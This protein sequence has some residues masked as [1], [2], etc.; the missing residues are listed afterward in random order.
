MTKFWLIRHAL[1]EEN[2]RAMLYGVMDVEL[3][4]HTLEAQAPHYALL[5][6]AL[7]RNATWYVTPL[8]RTRRTAETIM[9]HGYGEVPYGVEPGLI[10][11]N[12]GS[13]Q[14]LP[15]AQLPALLETPAH[16]FWPVSGDE[17]PPGGES[18]AEM[19]DRVG[20]AMEAL[21]AKHPD[22]DVVIVSHGGAIRA[23]ELLPVRLLLAALVMRSQV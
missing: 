15:H 19:I 4:P 5:A 7:P 8:S 16:P 14:G 23:A 9:R 2:A 10:E 3:C 17:R 11:Q 22:Q 20:D 6:K 13:W 18:F 1:V 12:L 21:A